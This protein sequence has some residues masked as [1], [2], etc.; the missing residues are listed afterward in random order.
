MSDDSAF[1]FRPKA[2]I[3]R[4]LGDELIG[5]QRLAIFELVKNAYDADAEEVVV[6]LAHL[7]T[8][9]ASIKVRDDGDG[10][11]ETTIRDVW[12]VPG[13]DHRGRQ[14]KEGRRS[15]RFN[16]LPL[17]E[18]G[19]GRF[20]VHKLGERIRLTTRAVG[21]PVERLVE[22]DWD[23]ILGD[24][25]LEDVELKVATREPVSFPGSSHGTEVEI[26]RLRQ[27]EWTRGDLRRLYRQVTSISSPFSAAREFSVE[28]RLPGREKDLIGLPSVGD[29]L[30]MALWHYTFSLDEN[31][32]LT[33]S[34]EFTNRLI[35]VEL[36]PRTQGGVLQSLQLDDQADETAEEVMP[37]KQRRGKN[38]RT[39]VVDAE[40]LKGIGPLEGEFFVFDRDKEVLGR[41]SEPELMTRYLTENGGIRVYRD[42]IR[43]YN[44]GERGDDWLGL[45]LRRVNQPTLRVSRNVVLGAINLSLEFSTK[46]V[47]K[48]NREGFVENDAYA[49]LRRIVLAALSAMEAERQQ[50]KDRLR[51]LLGTKGGVERF[52]ASPPIDALRKEAKRIQV[53]K[54]LEPYISRIEAEFESLKTTLVHAGFSG[55]GLAVVFHEIDRGVRELLASFKQGI[56]RQVLER[57]TT[58]LSL[59]LDG[60]ST[61]LRRSGRQPMQAKDLIRQARDIAAARFRYHKV[62]LDCPALEDAAS[63]FTAVM[64]RELMVGALTNLID[65]A[66]YWLRV[67]WPEPEEGQ[68][69]QRR[70]YIGTS[71]DLD[72]G[73]AIIVADNGP[74][75][76]D[77][78]DIV[79]KPF[80]TR[81][82]D[83]M[84]LGLYYVKLAMELSGGTVQF[85]SAA[86]VGLSDEFDGAVVALVFQGAKENG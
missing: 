41:M 9:L 67:R 28:L 15:K 39:I 50:D 54:E 33:W 49:R 16:R 13:A 37:S 86:D 47:E 79:T 42:A 44:Y 63:D 1:R 30:D 31:G 3:L 26:E 2:R 46:L 55:L 18:K 5:T 14:R 23:E 65:N 71:M 68:P 85:P 22:I 35:G 21:E 75:F 52:D 40:F 48:T 77:P 70:M 45:D 11:D 4:L 17:G 32:S 81:R 6:T 29:I 19:L 80:F 78:P 69:L 76:R 20:A 25:Y 24:G 83:G 62:H 8:P 66:I 74:G 27:E 7:G 43:V 82:P 60:F 59:L 51:Q 58:D 72:G 73:P 64:A 84:G 38:K 61:L 34:Y 53:D 57:K 12:F 56:E 10:M 36:A